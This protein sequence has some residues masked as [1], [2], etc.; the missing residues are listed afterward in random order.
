MSVHIKQR[1]QV[2]VYTRMVCMSSLGKQHSAETLD[3]E[4]AVA[5]S[6]RSL[7][8]YTNNY[9]S[10]R[11]TVLSG[12]FISYWPLERFILLSRMTELCVQEAVVRNLGREYVGLLKEGNMEVMGSCLVLSITHVIWWRAGWAGRESPPQLLSTAQVL[13]ESVDL[14]GKKTEGSHRLGRGLGSLFLYEKICFVLCGTEIKGEMQRQ[15][16]YEQSQP[17]HPVSQNE[18]I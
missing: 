4:W 14:G 5:Q 13:A 10:S 17:L 12:G 9:N 18:T 15:A 1:R 2:H 6:V 3:T 8:N 16:D 7:F 11:Q